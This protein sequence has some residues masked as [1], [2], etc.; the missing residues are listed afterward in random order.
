VT[1]KEPGTWKPC[2]CHRFSL[3]PQPRHVFAGPHRQAKS[4]QPY[5]LSLIARLPPKNFWSS[6]RGIG[7]RPVAVADWTRHSTLKIGQ[8]GRASA[9]ASPGVQKIK[10]KKDTAST[11]SVA[12]VASIHPIARQPRLTRPRPKPKGLCLLEPRQ[13]RETSSPLPRCRPAS[14]RIV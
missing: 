8:D 7:L 6:A 11:G 1:W 12:T 3:T 13:T 2:R 4:R 14:R 9:Q 10:G 5:R